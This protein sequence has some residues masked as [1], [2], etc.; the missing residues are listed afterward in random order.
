MEV[1]GDLG[2]GKDCGNKKWS[3]VLE[4]TVQIILP[5]GWFQA[6]GSRLGTTQEPEG[7]LESRE[8]FIW[9]RKT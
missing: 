9:I 5:K 1:T 4:K 6:K 2:R 8:Y 7:D 3:E